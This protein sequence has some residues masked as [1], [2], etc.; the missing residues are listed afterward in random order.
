VDTADSQCCRTV[1]IA[2][3]VE[4]VAVVVAAVVDSTVVDSMMVHLD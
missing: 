1:A 3:A 2:A 4:P